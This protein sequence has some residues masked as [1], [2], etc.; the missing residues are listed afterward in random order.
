MGWVEGC[1][2]GANTSLG[3]HG[4]LQRIWETYGLGDVCL[5]I[6]EG[7]SAGEFL[8]KMY[9]KIEFKT[10]DMRPEIKPDYVWDICT[11]LTPE[12]K[13][14]RGT[15][16][17]VLCQATLEHV[18]DPVGAMRSF[19]D[20]LRKGGF[21]FLHVPLTFDEHRFPIDCLRFLDDWFVHLPRYIPKLKLEF[22]ELHDNQWF[23]C[24]LKI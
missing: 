5:V 21:I 22:K 23:I 18:I 4:I 6:G 15:F 3:Y 16:G 12:L 20:L 11:K 24:F 2:P 10:V 17:S 1:V 9:P 8:H 7:E 13:K 19:T 14:L